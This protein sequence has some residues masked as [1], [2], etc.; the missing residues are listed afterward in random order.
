MTR[1]APAVVVL[2][3]LGGG[4]FELDSDRG[5]DFGATRAPCRHSGSLCLGLSAFTD[6]KLVFAQRA[7]DEEGSYCD[8]TKSENE[9]ETPALTGYG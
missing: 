9:C 2:L 6:Q 8:E 3:A 4:P 7:A 1:D 5:E